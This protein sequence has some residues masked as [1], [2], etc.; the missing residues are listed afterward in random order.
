MDLFKNEVV[1][2]LCDTK[3]GQWEYTEGLEYRYLAQQ[4]LSETLREFARVSPHEL[5]F[6]I[7]HVVGVVPPHQ[8]LQ[9]GGTIFIL[10]KVHGLPATGKIYISGSWRDVAGGEMITVH[11]GDAHGFSVLKGESLW[12]LSVDSPKLDVHDR[13]TVG[14]E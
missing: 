11:A 9:T 8:H 6:E 2:A 12:V 5:A 3:L 4:E 1:D 13:V 14:T 10:P 7:M